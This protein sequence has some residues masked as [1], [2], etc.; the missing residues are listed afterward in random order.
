MES[1]AYRRIVVGVDGS[2][3]HGVLARTRGT[4]VVRP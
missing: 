2:V 4:P 3:S 1:T